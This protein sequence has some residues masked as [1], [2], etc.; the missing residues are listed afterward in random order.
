MNKSLIRNERIGACRL[1]EKI[2]HR[3]RNEG[4][5]DCLNLGNKSELLTIEMSNI[6]LKVICIAA[7]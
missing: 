5:Q 1:R 7:I 6:E 4:M 3:R 2:K